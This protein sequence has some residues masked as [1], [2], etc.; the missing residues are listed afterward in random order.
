MIVTVG[1]VATDVL[2]VLAADLAPGSDTPATVRVA[3]GGQGANTAAWLAAAGA[4]VTFVGAVGDDG[5]GRDRVAELRAAGVRVQVSVSPDAGTGSVVV[6]VRDGERT[7]I[8]DRGANDRLDPRVAATAVAAAADDGARHLHLSGYTLFDDGS[9]PAGLAALR[10]AR[11]SGLTTSVDA[12]SAAPLRAAGP[13]F[14]TW[15]DGVDLLFANADE[16][17]VLADSAGTPAAMATAAGGAVVVKLGADGA[18]WADGDGVRRVRARPAAV[19]DSTGAGD[20]FA[21]GLLTAWVAG[22]DV[23]E[24]LAAGCR[25]GAVAVGATGARPAAGA[26]YSVAPADGGELR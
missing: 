12:A 22:A 8:S 2:A 17:D 18:V 13:D 9:R 14:L 21:A 4:A 6:L 26:R 23:P 3:G 11:D 16:A 15:V 10:Q 7:M 25:L 24:A 19:V 5:P 1:D 20:A